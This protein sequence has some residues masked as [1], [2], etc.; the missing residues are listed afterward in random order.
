MGESHP[1]SRISVHQALGDGS[2]ADLLLWRNRRGA[3]LLLGSATLFWFLFEKA[4]Y[5]FLSFVANVQLLFVVILFLWAK[6]ASLLNRPMPPL[7]SLE[8]SEASALKV[9][10]ALQV[11][12]NRALSVAHD[13][14]VGRNVKSLFQ[15][16]FVLWM[17]S[18]LGYFFNFLT[19]LYLG[20][21]LSLSVPVLY[22]RYQDNIDDKLSVT[23]RVLQ[24]QY[25]KIDETL[26]Q[27]IGSRVAAKEKK[28][29]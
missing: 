21:I 29:Q 6:S 5:N 12:L 3:V 13:I 24:T 20:A 23:H 4:G 9:S 16:S 10:D 8:I 2:V 11:W 25:R 14:A 19:L 1:H 18:L 22:E 17:V 26:L 28:M 7:P 15:V 27:K